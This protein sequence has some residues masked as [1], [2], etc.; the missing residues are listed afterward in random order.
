MDEREIVDEF[1]AESCDHLANIES[2]LLAIEANGATID[3]ELV[4][5]VFRA[6]HSIKGT[7][8]FLQ[9]NTIQDLSHE[10]ETV[11]NL[12]RNR[13]LVP[14][15]GITDV[16][17][18][19]ADTL[20][21]L[22]EN[23]DHSSEVDVSHHVAELQAI[24]AG[25]LPAAPAAPTTT[26][27]EQ[28]LDL[29]QTFVDEAA[30][31]PA[32]A[33]EQTQAQATSEP[34]NDTA[35]RSSVVVKTTGHTPAVEANIRVSV[36]VLDHLMNLAGELVLSR[37]QLLQTVGTKNSG[38]LD[39]I[40]ARLNQVTSEIQEA[41]MQ[42]RLQVV[43][44]V[45][46]KFPR[47]V[48]DLCNTLGKQCDLVVEGED[49]E[50]DKSIIEAIGDPLTH[51]IRNAV[52]HGL[53]SPEE[54][55]ASGKSPKGKIL[56]KA[57]HQA[58]KVHMVVRDDGAGIDVAKLKQKAIA[59]GI[60]TA[61]QAHEM[62]ERESLRLIFRPG[63]STANELTNISGRGVGM[64][65]VRTNIERLGGTVDVD[66]HVGQGTAVNLTLPL[67]LAI[68]PSLIVRCGS[69]RFAI[70]QASISE[71]VRVRAAE[72][73]EKLQRVNGAEVLRLRGNLL[74][75]VRLSS[76]LSL[77]MAILSGAV[78]QPETTT[79]T[80][81]IVVESGHLRYGLIVDAL[82]DSEEIV[83]KP[84]GKNMKDCRCFAGATILGDGQ[85]ALILDVA[86]LA[87]QASLSI[88]EDKE[89]SESADAAA[90][91]AD[92]SQA[93]LLFTNAPTEQF[94][95]PMGLISRLERIRADQIDAVG[96]QEVLQYRGASLTLMSLENHLRALP[97][98]EQQRLYVIVFRV[99][100]REIGLIVPQLTDIRSVSTDIDTSTFREPGVTGSVVIDGRVTRLLDLLEL[101]R[102]AHAEWFYET[103]L[104]ASHEA[105]TP[106]SP[107][108][109]SSDE[110]SKQKTILLAEDSSFFRKQLT[111]FLEA[112]GY[113]V[114]ACEDGQVAWDVL[115]HPGKPCDLIVTDLEMPN[116][117]G[118]GLTERV[119][120]TPSIC[121]LPII[122]VTS[123]AS[124]EDVEHGR[125]VG[126]DEYH[127]KLD[128]ERLMASVAAR[129]RLAAQE[130]EADAETTGRT[131]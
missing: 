67:T 14:N 121:H 35:D 1:V 54:R 66:S 90:A 23:V 13:E 62:G 102:S 59:N 43:E 33:P 118:F 16:L 57:F 76:A 40:S 25:Q 80:N 84:M 71:L 4:N 10:M 32:P 28:T 38:N 24:A 97:R 111:G 89:R 75:L 36:R 34:A 98:P 120:K 78:D 37:N 77:K 73:A 29:V 9:L 47:V 124:D 101:T 82:H 64:D 60:I 45:F 63:F 92:D 26:Q 74:P 17:L 5:T 100:T 129:L 113:R 125:R 105:T 41:V 22:V 2:Q 61:E 91:T 21:S 99:G 6:V 27:P 93:M 127:V 103:S 53:E 12:I 109:G 58:G 131:T 68:I 83:V 94:A 72:R 117:D 15:S 106:M 114:L 87:T 79:N 122:A 7:A 85:V 107:H 96:G 44:T 128:R 108:L 126:V 49:V 112:D 65:V 42:T 30:S 123:L 110:P 19:A 56:L 3:V 48:R 51:L 39:S 20:R 104:S 119:R 31:E 52:D 50:L 70:P 116:L 130:A 55:I 81:I 69:G 88:H 11:L 95:V 18:R 115:C 46:S 86:G 8:G